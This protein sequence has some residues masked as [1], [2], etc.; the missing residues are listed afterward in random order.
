MQQGEVM[1][2]L[3]T[4]VD[5]LLLCVVLVPLCL[6]A[7]G[8]EFLLFGAATLE[9]KHAAWVENVG[10]P[11]AVTLLFIKIQRLLTSLQSLF[12]LSIQ[13]MGHAELAPG[14][15][16]F[17][18]L[19]QCFEGAPGGVIQRDGGGVLALLLINQA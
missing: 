11:P 19:A 5:R 4:E 17:S 3:R 2:S 7:F 1:L 12:H 18:R 6:I 8:L 14:L 13:F 10:Y 16:G 9:F 15:R